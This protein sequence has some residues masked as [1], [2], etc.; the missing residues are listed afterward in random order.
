MNGVFLLFNRLIDSIVCGSRP[1]IRS[2]TRTAT[3]QRP[4]PRE[5][6][7]E[8]DSWPGV[9]MTSRP[10]R[11]R[12]SG[13][14]RSILS[15]SLAFDDDDD[16]PSP[17][18][19]FPPPPPS[20]SGAV[21]FTTAS[22]GMYVAPICCVIPPASPSCT[23]VRRTL[24]SSLVFPVS[25]WPRMQQ[26]GERRR[27]GSARSFARAQRAARRCLEASRARS[28]AAPSARRRATA[29]EEGGGTL[30]SE[31]AEGDEEKA[32]SSPP[33]KK[34]DEEDAAALLLPSPPLFPPLRL[35]L[36]PP[37]SAP[38]AASAAREAW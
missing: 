28:R 21:L 32:P 3:S 16:A 36:F 35:I 25:T 5:R 15:P 12:S 30:A 26:I 9:S 22:A 33:P 8:K 11:R 24:S 4:E 27:L 6:R 13:A 7:L 23:L 37:S 2:T 20:L 19:P 18:P 1:C 31:G 17:S 34:G 10:G 29:R 14:Q 38:A